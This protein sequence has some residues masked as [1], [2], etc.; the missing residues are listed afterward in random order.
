MKPQHDASAIPA[1]AGRGVVR[2]LQPAGAGDGGAIA[3]VVLRLPSLQHFFY[4]VAAMVLVMLGL[5]LGEPILVPLALLSFMLAPLVTWLRAWRVPHGLAVGLV[6]G[7][8]L[9][10]LTALGTTLW[11]QVSALSRDMPTYQST[12]QHKLGQLRRDLTERSSALQS[13]SAVIGVVEKELDQTRKALGPSPGQAAQSPPA[14][15]VVQPP[16]PSPW[17]RP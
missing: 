5:V 15:V 1:S 13:V 10:V 16:D 14:V 4:S 17:R 6:L 3:S 7:A 12:V 8:L 11:H 9:G 2:S